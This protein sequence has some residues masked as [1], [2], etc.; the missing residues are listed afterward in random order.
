MECRVGGEFK[1]NVIMLEGG[2]YQKHYFFLCIKGRGGPNDYAYMLCKDYKVGW[3][4]VIA[5]KNNNDN[6]PQ[7]NLQFC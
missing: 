2:W 6:N 5:R 7:A 4:F 1:S 3:D